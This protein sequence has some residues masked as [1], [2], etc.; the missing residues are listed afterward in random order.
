M[1]TKKSFDA[2]VSPRP[3]QPFEAPMVDGQRFCFSSIEEFIAGRDDIAALI[4]SG[5]ILHI[6]IG[7]IATIRPLGTRRGSAARRRARPA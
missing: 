6:G 2:Y 5:D 7:F 1:M 4:K 3:F